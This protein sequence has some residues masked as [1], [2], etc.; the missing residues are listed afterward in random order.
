MPNRTREMSAL[1]LAACKGTR[2]KSQIPKV[3]HP[4]LG[5]PMVAYIAETCAKAGIKQIFLVIGHKADRVREVLGDGYRYIEQT[6][7]LGTGHALMLAAEHLKGYSGDLMVLA[8]DTPFLTERLLKRL[9]G[10][11]PKTPPR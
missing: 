7:Q 3:L 4:L 5:K 6:Q 10:Q 8:G 2:M 1:I 9:L 11:H